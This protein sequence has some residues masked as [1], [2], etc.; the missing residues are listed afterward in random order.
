MEAEEY[1][2]VYPATHGV[3]Q[4]LLEDEGRFSP[5]MKH[6]MANKFSMSYGLDLILDLSCL[7]GEL[8]YI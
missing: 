6:S 4:C 1:L 3:W 5:P 8:E 7:I 2:I